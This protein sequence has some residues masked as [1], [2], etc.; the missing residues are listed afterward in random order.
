MAC[1][2]AANEHVEVAAVGAGGNVAIGLRSGGRSDLGTFGLCATGAWARVGKE[3]DAHGCLGLP[4]MM[5]TALKFGPCLRHR[6]QAGQNAL[7]PGLVMKECQ[8]GTRYSPT[9]FLVQEGQLPRR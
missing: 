4:G 6:G 7:G 8:I 1:Q 2:G 5:Q 9:W 3:E